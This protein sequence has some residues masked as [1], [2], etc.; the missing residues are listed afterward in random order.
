MTTEKLKKRFVL[1]KEPFNIEIRA[2]PNHA[3][4]TYFT[5]CLFK[6][7]VYYIVT[8]VKSGVFQVYLMGKKVRCYKLFDTETLFLSL[9]FL[10]H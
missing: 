6:P 2:E 10:R 8:S 7:F 9:E 5:L 3:H 4:I 1:N